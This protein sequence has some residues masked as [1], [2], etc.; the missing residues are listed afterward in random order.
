MPWHTVRDSNQRTHGTVSRPTIDVNM[1]RNT[2]YI[3]DRLFLATLQA[4]EPVCM[5]QRVMELERSFSAAQEEIALL[6]VERD[7]LI[8]SLKK[9]AKANHIER[10]ELLLDAATQDLRRELQQLRVENRRLKRVN[11]DLHA[12]PIAAASVRLRA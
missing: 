12:R 8:A 1:A 11:N 2:T 6:T 7:A 5:R 4:P 9:W 3:D 10:Q